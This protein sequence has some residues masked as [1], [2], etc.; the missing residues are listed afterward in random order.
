MADA[1]GLPGARPPRPGRGGPGGGG[2]R[3]GGRRPSAARLHRARG[4][5]LTW[6]RSRPGRLW[7]HGRELELLHRSMGFSALGLVTLMPLLIVVAAV[8]PLQPRGFAEW[9]VHG[10]G[11]AGGPADTVRHLFSPPRRVLSTTSALGV[12]ALVLFGLSFAAS[13]QTG[14]EKVWGL[15]AGPWHKV[16][17][18]AVW[19]T[20]LTACLFG[21]AQSGAVLRHGWAQPAARAL[22]TLL[23]G[24]LFF[25]WGQ[26]FLLGGR[27]PWRALLPGAAATV[28][29]LVGLRVFSSLVFAPLIVSN[30][31]AYGVVGTVLVVQSWLIGAGFVVFGGAMLGRHAHERHAH[32]PRR[33]APPAASGGGVAPKG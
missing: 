3:R 27:V 1:D 12:A 6:H 2:R 17:R 30:A 24:L 22:L 18:Q 32:P 10:M 26:R 25:W 14:Y 11:L 33:P 9:L 5:P 4:L 7:R 19:L 16:W 28:L 15:P 20:V 29:G 21:T 31:V 8:A 13:V 23:T